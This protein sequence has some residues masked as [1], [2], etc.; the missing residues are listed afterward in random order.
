MT[1]G[2]GIFQAEFLDKKCYAVIADVVIQRP[3]LI[4]KFIEKFDES[5]IIAAFLL[6]DQRPVDLVRV[7]SYQLKL[8]PFKF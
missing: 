6:V 5:K 8:E 7:D 4:S 2:N 1:V 3:Y